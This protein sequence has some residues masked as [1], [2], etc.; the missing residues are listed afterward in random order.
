VSLWDIFFSHKAAE[1]HKGSCLMDQLLSS[2][3]IENWELIN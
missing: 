2:R 3:S 1:G